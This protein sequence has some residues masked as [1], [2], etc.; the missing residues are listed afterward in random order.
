MGTRMGIRLR[1]TRA[2]SLRSR[3]VRSPGNVFEAVLIE[4][5][6]SK[7]LLVPVRGRRRCLLAVISHMNL[8]EI[9]MEI[10]RM[11]RLYPEM[12][13]ESLCMYNLTNGGPSLN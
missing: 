12:V 1:M 5:A 2:R 10:N 11:I 13:Y 4:M 3:S 9:V 8:T 7:E 6:K